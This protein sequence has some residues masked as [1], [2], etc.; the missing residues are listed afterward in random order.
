MVGHV[1]TPTRHSVITGR[2]L[3]L[4]RDSS[5]IC[6]PRE[7]RFDDVPQSMGVQ[8]AEMWASRCKL[9]GHIARSGVVT[10]A[11]TPLSTPPGPDG[12]ASAGTSS[13]TYSQ[14]KSFIKTFQVICDSRARDC[15][16]LGRSNGSCKGA[17]RRH[18]SMKRQT[19]GFMRD[20][21]AGGFSP[22]HGFSRGFA[23]CFIAAGKLWAADPAT[24]TVEHL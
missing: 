14:W 20:S 8:L 21:R 18:I 17:S 11:K 4:N 23:L 15:G 5:T 13:R 24:Y 1:P 19:D 16:C 6:C 12:M 3:L 22:P 2:P 7:I 10:P 9:T